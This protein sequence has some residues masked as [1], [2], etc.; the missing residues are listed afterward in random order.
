MTQA[1]RRKSRRKRTSPPPPRF[2]LSLPEGYAALV[3]GVLFLC[4]VL[5]GG[6]TSNPGTEFALECAVAGLALIGVWFTGRDGAPRPIP[7]TALALAGLAL[8][9]PVAQLI[10]LPPSLWHGLPGRQAEIDAL[11]LIGQAQHWMPLSMAPART[12]AALLAI[13]VEV[14]LFVAVA[15]LDL[16]G[17]MQLC[18]VIVVVG[19]MAAM[20]GSLQLSNAG[21]YHWVLYEDTNIGWV[22][23]F[24]ANR[25]AATDTFQIAILAVAT[26]LGLATANRKLPAMQIGLATLLMLTFAI[27]AVLTGSRTGMLLLP[28]TYLFA[29]WLAWPLLKRTSRYLS[30][31]IMLLV[32]VGGLALAATGPVQQAL[33]RFAIDND[34]RWD[35]WHDTLRATGSVWPIGS[36]IGSFQ[37][38]YDSAQSIERMQTLLDL[39]AH[40]DWLE[41]VLEAGI[42][43]L[44]VLAVI[45]AILLFRNVAALRQALHV[46]ADPRLR[47]Q[48][49][50]ATGTLLHL[51]L[52]GI[53]DYPVR[54]MAL[55][56]LA[57]TAAAMLMPAP[58]EGTVQQ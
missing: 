53:F 56:A 19:L 57:A 20:L 4:L 36:G 5:G 50:F 39:R 23:G 32:P 51:G 45:G 11:A 24:H 18:A 15:R 58:A 13:I 43:G 21:G 14:G 26:Y 49:L 40:N 37:V 25:N 22:V 35:I 34:H 30:W 16:R 47:A 29:V 33:G 54:S 1:Q 52:H 55:A 3:A 42:P 38:A 41:W 31:G 7:P 2:R 28:L 9:I 6:G 17:R 27:A 48:A 8:L 44:I 46:N 12:F 10:P